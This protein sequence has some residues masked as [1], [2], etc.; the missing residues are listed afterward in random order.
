[1]DQ[2]SWSREELDSFAEYTIGEIENTVC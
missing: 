2:I 1:M